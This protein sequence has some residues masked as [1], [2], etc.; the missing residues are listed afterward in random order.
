MKCR[1]SEDKTL[2]GRRTVTLE[3]GLIE[4]TIIPSDGGRI[5]GIID[6][7]SSRNFIWTNDRTAARLRVYGANY[8]DLSAGGIEEAFPTG[9]PSTYRGDPIPFFGEVWA[10][11]WQY[12]IMENSNETII[13]KLECYCSIYPV[14]VTKYIK[15][16]KYQSFVEV[17]YKILNIGFTDLDFIMGVHPSFNI[18]PQCILELPEAVYRTGFTFPDNLVKGKDKSFTWPVLEDMNL[19]NIC[20]KNSARCI[21]V[22]TAHAG[23]GE[24]S[25]YDTALD[26]GLAVVYDESFFKALS[27]WMIYGGWRGHY[28]I[29]SEFFTGW[30]L[31]LHEAVQNNAHNTIR[32]NQEFSTSTV[33]GLFNRQN[34][35]NVLDEIRNCVFS[36]Y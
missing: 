4:V 3:N 13:L 19:S 1:I 36:A 18:S 5:T 31:A 20:D 24:L 8:D 6:K 12:E 2:F 9:L 10:V 7:A 17:N 11:P 29:M 14:R 27:V 25:I 34:R 30:P 22:Y 35:N 23:H 28:C 26:S 15:L 33:Y 32:P 21:Q 16:K